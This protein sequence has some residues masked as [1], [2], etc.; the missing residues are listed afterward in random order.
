MGSMD[1]I[2][3]GRNRLVIRQTKEWGEI[4][5]GFEARNRFEILD[6]SGTLLGRAAEEEGGFG[7]M[8]A[9]NFFGKCRA[10]RV[11][12]CGPDGRELGRGEKP[13]R[14]F[15]HRMDVFDGDRRIG[16]IQRRWAWFDR[17]FSVENA[18]GREVMTILSPLFRIWTFKLLYEGREV[19]R[20]SKEWGGLL[21]EAFSDAD[22]FGVEF[23]DE[24]LPAE[25]RKLL[26]VATFLVD[27]TCFENN[28]NRSGVFDP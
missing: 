15:F 13:F 28:T 7:R 22:T 1:E 8:L 5:I 2:V 25:V 10:C 16:A 14:W 3:G 17:R 27:F 9:R 6:D 19:G 18:E 4:L 11:H 26:L 20:I 24:R 21:R 23:G 12:V